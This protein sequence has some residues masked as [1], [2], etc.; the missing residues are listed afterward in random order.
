MRLEGDVLVVD[1]TAANL[2]VVSQVLENSGCEVAVAL[3]GD[4][5]LKLVHLH[6]PDLILLDVQMPGIDG[7]ETC[8]RL[9]SNL[10]TRSIP[11]IFMTALSDTQSKLKGFD[12]G[13]VDYITKPFQAKELLVRVRTHL[14]LRQLHKTLQ[15]R[16]D[17][18]T[19]ELQTTL[20]RLHE[21]QLQL[22]QNEK[23]S[24]LGNMIAGIAHEFNNPLGFL[25]G[26]ISNANNHLEELIDHLSLY[27]EQYPD[28]TAEIVENAEEIELDFLVEDFLKL[29]TSM[30]VATD[31]MKSMSTS[32][33]N[34]SR[35]DTEQIVSADLHEGL[36]GTL[37]LLTYRLK[38][39]EHRPE[40]TVIRDY[41]ELP[42]VKCFPGQL[43]QVFMNI[44]AN[45]ID[46]FDEM[47]SESSSLLSAGAQQIKISTMICAD[48]VEVRIRDNGKGMSEVVQSKIFD[49]SFTTKAVG[50][51]TGLGLSISRQIVMDN[52]KGK[53]D[54]MSTL[55]EGSEFCIR[56]P[57]TVPS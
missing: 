7:F 56:L 27:Q 43:N 34:Y 30:K 20:E 4:R 57:L 6:P 36:D 46:M 18:K 38:G 3:D 42:A 19:S 26:S 35:A 10:S 9:K 28:A 8:K 41:A 53:L 25:S 48:E 17:A 54:V 14:Q 13:G 37:L 5:A 33:R 44:L 21:S 29:L 12:A 55:G 52:H 39:N 15:C 49:R 32:L 51:G 31:R 1:D 45:M 24:A 16:V 40:I 11:V 47:A 23:M 22:V 2:E 50:K